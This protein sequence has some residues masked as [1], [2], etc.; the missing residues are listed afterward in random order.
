[1]MVRRDL[2]KNS[3]VLA[4]NCFITADE[5]DTHNDALPN[6][7]ARSL[8]RSSWVITPAICIGARALPA[9]LSRS[10]SHHAQGSQLG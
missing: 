8:T 2:I 10:P 1:M 9:R 3:R 5:D 6:S 4:R 7:R